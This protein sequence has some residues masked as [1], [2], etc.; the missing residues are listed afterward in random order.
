[1]DSGCP[2]ITALK[3]LVALPIT[4]LGDTESAEDLRGIFSPCSRSD[5]VRR[6]VPEQFLSHA[7][8]YAKKYS[9]TG[10][11]QQYLLGAFDLLHLDAEKRNALTILDVGS[12]AGNTIF[13]LLSLCPG[14]GV[15]ASDLSVDLLLLLKKALVQQELYEHCLLLQLNVEELNFVPATFDLVVGGAILHHLFSPDKTIGGCAQIL[16]S[17]GAAI[18]FEPFEIGHSL[19]ELA[20]AEILRDKRHWFLRRRVKEFLCSSIKEYQ[21]RRGS[22]K[23]LPV[24]TQ[25]DDKWLFTRHYFLELASRYGFSECI[26]YPLHPAED[27]LKNHTEIYL[28]L[29]S[30]LPGEALPGW[31][32][33][34]IARYDHAFSDDAMKDMLIEAAVILRK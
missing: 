30:D 2:G 12:G 20:Y 16:E 8:T 28:R 10:L 5:V 19:L 23:S 11:F 17:G 29:A 25:I 7:Q 14:S 24:Y 3:R 22:N 13:P 32:W 34:I 26:I 4:D 27:Q 15:I 6:H 18:F 21:T 9:S 1:M 33:K 31:A